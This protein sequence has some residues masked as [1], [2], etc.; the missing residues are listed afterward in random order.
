MAITFQN[1]GIRFQ[2]KGRLKLKD[3]I[4]RVILSEKKRPGD[5]NFVFTSDEELL[6]VNQQYLNHN[7]YTDIITFDS[8]EGLNING[9]IM[10]SAERVA[11]NSQK[12]GIESQ[13]E[14]KRVMIHGVLH[15]C[16]YKD[17]SKEES[18]LMRKK[19]NAALRKW[20]S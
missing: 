4:R 2:L 5:I 15:L 16:G 9:D 19:E 13:H 14:L 3:W 20:D 18:E 10:I 12:L 8:C 11:E 6:K 17:K 7:T 1:Q